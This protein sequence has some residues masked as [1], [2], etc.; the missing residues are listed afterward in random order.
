VIGKIKIEAVEKTSESITVDWDV[1]TLDS[2]RA[3]LLVAES[4]A[5][6]DE[7][8]IERNNIEIFGGRVQNPRINFGP[9][10]TGMTVEGYDY[11]IM[12]QDFL[13]LA[14]NIPNHTTEDALAHILENW[15][16]SSTMEGAFSYIS[17]L[18]EWV[19][20]LEFLK[21]IELYTNT[22]IEFAIEAPEINDEHRVGTIQSFGEGG[23]HNCFF[24]DGTT[25]RFYIFYTEGNVIFYDHSVDG[26]TWVRVSTTYACT[27]PRFGVAWHSNKVYL[28]LEDAGGN[29]DF[30]RGTITD[31]SGTIAFVYRSQP[32]TNPMRFGPVWD[33]QGDIWI[34]EEVAR[35][36]AWESTTDGN[37]WVARFVAPA[38]HNLWGVLPIGANGDMMGFVVDVLGEDLEEWLWDAD[39]P[40]FARVRDIDGTNDDID[41]LQAAINHDYTPWVCWRDG[42]TVTVNHLSAGVWGVAGSA[43]ITNENRY[44]SFCCDAGIGAYLIQ[45]RTGGTLVYKFLAG[46][47]DTTWDV[48]STYEWHVSGALIGGSNPFAEEGDLGVFFC[49]ESDGDGWFILFP[50]TGIRLYEGHATGSFRTAAVT[51]SGA[52]TPIVYWGVLTSENIEVH[53][54]WSILNNAD[55]L[56]LG[57]IETPYDLHYEG[58]LD[59]AQTVVKVFCDLEKTDGDP[60]VAAFDLSER[61]DQ[62]TMDTDYE[63]CF[64]GV[65]RLADLAGAEF[66]VEKVA[67]VYTLHFSTRRG[68]D[69]SNL[70]VLKNSKTPD[71]PDVEPNVKFL[72]KTFDWD[73][74]A[75]CIQTI[76]GTVD[77]VR[78]EATLKDH[79]EIASF[80]QEV[81][82]TIRDAEIIT[83]SMARQ[84]AAIELLSRHAVTL[85]ITGRF[86]DEYDP[87]D[88]EIGDS[89]MLVAEWDEGALKIT[90]SHRIIQLTREYGAGGEQVGASFSNQMKAV[91]YWNYMSKTDTHERWITA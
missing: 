2:F 56:L 37:S 87:K 66:W 61:I 22:C 78:I 75:N 62:V 46:A 89:V 18:E 42:S 67:G 63:D 32:F 76:G 31:L 69:K 9:G 68:L 36:Q 79:T 41:G 7:A 23:L 29:T 40:P 13:T 50:P 11:T 83:V 91:E 82:K 34:V 39:A 6:Y 35:G 81:W 33:D 90:G 19:T 86:L 16:H 54:D 84:K 48:P 57:G 28:F 1:R 45:N 53:D 60:Y 74:Y 59:P 24:Y 43:G 47:L 17:L 65:Q 38:D 71:Y 8:T 20:S 52:P 3:R 72:E 88:I 25:E 15:P 64:I 4:L 73:R 30:Y 10:G 21:D 55:A 85:R 80:G 77:D 12:L 27:T 5:G 14:Q 58:G 44:F 51:A 26:V 70:V 49:G